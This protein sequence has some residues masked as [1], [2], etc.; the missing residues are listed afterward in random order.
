MLE[1]LVLGPIEAQDADGPIVI[2]SRAQRALL[3]FLANARGRVV[4]IPDLIALLWGDD[5]PASAY[6]TLKSHVSRLRRTLRQ[7][8]VVSRP[9]GYAL[10]LPRD[11]L[12]LH[13]FE[14]GVHAA[15]CVTDIE[16]V[17]ALWRGRPYGEFSDHGPLVGDVA[18][19]D[20]IHAQARVRRADLMLH[21]GQVVQA[22][23]AY[24]QL[25]V[26]DPQRETAWTGL[27][28]ALHAAGRQADATT[29]ARRYRELTREV[30]LDPSPRFLQAEDAVFTSEP[31]V[32]TPRSAGVAVPARLSSFVGRHRELE[33]VRGLIHHRRLVTLVGPGGVGKTALAMEAARGVAQHVDDGVRIVALADI[34]D[35]AAVV[36]A[37][38]RAVEAPTTEPL[39]AALERFLAGRQVLLMLD[40]AEHVRDAVRAAALRLLAGCDQLRMLVTSRQPLDISGEV[41]VPVQPLARGAALEVFCQRAPATPAHQSR[42]NSMPLPPRSVTGS[43]GSRWRSRWPQCGCVAWAW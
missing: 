39:D 19:L 34:S 9:P 37:I 17:L 8:V 30:G 27:L 6:P 29:E 11:R 41:V 3:A 14:H 25:S 43:T 16:E 22:A 2:G 7:D 21:E 42:R 13:R 5:P 38:C 12:D 40:N 23:A 32:V 1:V 31:A 24:K 18:R 4:P 36:A 28:T 26:E 15:S 20:E 10:T 35:K 33:E